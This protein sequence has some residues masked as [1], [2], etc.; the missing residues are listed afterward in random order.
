MTKVTKRPTQQKGLKAVFN[1]SL[2]IPTS[3]AATTYHKQSTRMNEGEIEFRGMVKATYTEL[4]PVLEKMTKDELIELVCRKQ[5]VINRFKG[6]EDRYHGDWA[7]A[8]FR[9]SFIEDP[10]EF[11][12]LYQ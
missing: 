9:K 11:A 8:A 4:T 6:D 10:E 2:R 12:K 7:K 5:I 3:V 1:R